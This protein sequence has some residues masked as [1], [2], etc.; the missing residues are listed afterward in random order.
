[1]L[2]WDGESFPCAKIRLDNW[3]RF[4]SWERES[5]P[6]SRI[7]GIIGS[8]FKGI[9][10]LLGISWKFPAG[11]ELRISH[12]PGLGWIIGTPVC[13]YRLAWGEG[14]GRQ[15]G[16]QPTVLPCHSAFFFRKSAECALRSVH[17]THF[18]SRCSLWQPASPFKFSFLPPNPTLL[19]FSAYF[20]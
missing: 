19:S 2:G 11:G 7:K 5:F 1:V 13:T 14:V 15:F 8:T 12:V 10:F 18:Y 17:S 20:K 9:I 16:L 4:S 3:Y 6:W